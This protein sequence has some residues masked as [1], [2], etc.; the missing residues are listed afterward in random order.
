M[1]IAGDRLLV[2]LLLVCLLG[3]CHT[4]WNYVGSYAGSNGIEVLP[5]VAA[6]DRDVHPRTKVPWTQGVTEPPRLSRS[7]G[8][9]LPVRLAP[10]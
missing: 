1:Q 5:P 6:A 8:D 2:E 10:P 7:V 9:S 4:Y 3:G